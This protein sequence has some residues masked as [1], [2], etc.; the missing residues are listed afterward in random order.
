MEVCPRCDSRFEA[1]HQIVELGMKWGW[2]N[3]PDIPPRLSCPGCQMVFRSKTYRY[4]GFIS[5]TALKMVIL[6]YTLFFSIAVLVALLWE[7][8]FK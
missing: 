8:P 5:P 4:F 2:L 3:I 6:V 7:E 1:K